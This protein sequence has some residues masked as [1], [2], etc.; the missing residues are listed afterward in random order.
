MEEKTPSL[1]R[2][3]MSLSFPFLLQ[4]KDQ[5][6]HSFHIA[7]LWTSQN[8]NQMQLQPKKDKRPSKKLTVSFGNEKWLSACKTVGEEINPLLFLVCLSLFT[9]KVWL[10]WGD[11][12]GAA[13]KA[14]GNRIGQ[15]T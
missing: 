3:G 13:V 9:S 11:V 8:Q 10:L 12:K 1:C 5:K 2:N 6:G 7:I 14:E 4:V 15:T